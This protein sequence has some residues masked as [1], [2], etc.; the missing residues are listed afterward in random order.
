MWKIIHNEPQY[1]ISSDGQVRRIRTGHVKSLRK[2][3][4]GYLR[5]TLYPSGKTYTIHRLVATAFIPND[6]NLATVN[7]MDGNKENNTVQNLEWAS[8]STNLKH[9]HST[10]LMEYDNHGLKNPMAKFNQEDLDSIKSLKSKGYTTSEI[11]KE[12]NVPY[13]RVRRFLVGQHYRN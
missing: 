6:K 13:E 3:R 11:A 5:V 12:L 4:Y 1:E 10:G 8:V 7:H 2:D 9:A